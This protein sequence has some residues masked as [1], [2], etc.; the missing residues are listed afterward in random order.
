[1]VCTVMCAAQWP[2]A[3]GDLRHAHPSAMMAR[4]SATSVM[5]E[6][7]APKAPPVTTA[8]ALGDVVWDSTECPKLNPETS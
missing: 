2:D 8:D 1:M 5:T 6:P 4:I 3:P 7:S